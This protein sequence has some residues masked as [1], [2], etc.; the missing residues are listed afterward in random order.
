MLIPHVLFIEKDFEKK[1]K[2]VVYLYGNGFEVVPVSTTNEALALLRVSHFDLVLTASH[3]SDGDANNFIQTMKAAPSLSQIPVIVTGQS[4]TSDESNHYRNQGAVGTLSFTDESAVWI[5]TLRNAVNLHQNEARHTH[6]GISGQLAQTP[7][8]EL[9]KQL[10]E[11][12]GTGMLL[13]DGVLPMEIH[14]REGQLVHARYGITVGFKALCR[15]LLIAEAAYH[16]RKGI[17]EGDPTIKGELDELLDSA[18]SA[19]QKLMANFHRL[20]STQYRARVVGADIF[21]NAKL[22]PEVRAAL[23]IIRKYPR[24]GN[25]LDRLNLPDVVCYE[26]LMTFLERGVIELVT[27]TKPVQIMTDSSCDIPF[28]MLQDLGIITLPVRLA[29][30]KEVFHPF[31]PHEELVLYEKKTKFLELGEL[32]IP[33]EKAVMQR[34]EALIP[35]Y[36]CLILT[37]AANQVPMFDHLNS[38]AEKIHE[39]G[40]EGRRLLA[41][42][43]SVINTHSLSIGLG[44]LADYAAHLASTGLQVEQIEEKLLLGMARLHLYFVVNPEN[45]VLVKKGNAS[46]ILG[47]DGVN[48]TLFAKLNRVDDPLEILLEEASKR[49]DNKSKLHL[50]LADIHNPGELNRFRRAF[51]ER[52]AMTR[53]ILS[54][55]GP[56][57]GYL[58]GKGALAVAFFQE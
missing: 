16:F 19:N 54:A 48:I 7:I 46:V 33:D 56:T 28:E 10:A 40:F 26:Y 44:L 11:E 21:E 34:F 2:W 37:P 38:C 5:K 22:K 20:P 27:E 29:I 12:E 30:G 25:Y 35:D 52:F 49:T 4:L 3:L 36:D 9:I 42:E 13:I 24:I 43:L 51:E 53:P 6:R 39:E 15:C 14:F 17:V 57:T 47:W 23:E 8:S 41:N 31:R 58:L 50:A 55:I 45:S 18:R 1:Q 32:Q